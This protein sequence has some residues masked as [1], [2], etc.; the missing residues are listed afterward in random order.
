M[1]RFERW[2]AH[3]ILV[4]R[5]PLQICSSV[6]WLLSVAPAIPGPADPIPVLLHVSEVPASKL[7]AL[8]LQAGSGNDGVRPVESGSCT[9]CGWAEVDRLGGVGMAL[10]LAM[11]LPLTF[12]SSVCPFSIVSSIDVPSAMLPVISML[13]SGCA[14]PALV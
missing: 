3:L 11:A 6:P 1:E 4:F 10:V 2:Q 12:A 13:L 14:V 7:L 8:L 9:A 5:Q